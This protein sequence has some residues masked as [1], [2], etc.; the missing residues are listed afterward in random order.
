MLD[1]FTLCGT[2]STCFLLLG[3][4]GKDHLLRLKGRTPY[5]SPTAWQ[6]PRWLKLACDKCNNHTRHE[7]ERE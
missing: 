4:P 3:V 7:H 2:V 1:T 6:W 5:I